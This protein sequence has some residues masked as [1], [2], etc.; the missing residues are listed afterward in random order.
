MNRTFRKRY[1]GIKFGSIQKWSTIGYPGL[2]YTITFLSLL[3]TF[4]T[5]FDRHAPPVRTIC[6]K[7]TCN[8]L[9]AY[10]NSNWHSITIKYQPRT[11]YNLEYIRVFPGAFIRS[12]ATSLIFTSAG[13]SQK[14]WQLTSSCAQL[15]IRHLE[16]SCKF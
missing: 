14:F 4:T 1:E 16:G 13:T 2:A 15:Y 10:Y 7:F 8:Q 6:G 12:K 11:A 5:C 3:R 9:S